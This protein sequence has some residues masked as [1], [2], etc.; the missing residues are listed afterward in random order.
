MAMRAPYWKGLHQPA[1]FARRPEMSEPAA[2]I[3]LSGL[4]VRL[5]LHFGR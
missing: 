5:R 4:G 1:A 2:K 3:Q